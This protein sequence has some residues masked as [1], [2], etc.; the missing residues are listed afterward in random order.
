MANPKHIRNE[1]KEYLK[2]IS[3][4]D[5]PRIVFEEHKGIYKTAYILIKVGK[6]TNKTNKDD[7]E[8]QYSEGEY[9]VYVGIENFPNKAPVIKFLTPNGRYQKDSPICLNGITHYHDGGWNFSN[10][11]HSTLPQSL[12]GTMTDDSFGIRGI[13]YMYMKPEERLK[14][15]SSS[16]EFN[17]INYPRI[18][19]MFN[20]MEPEVLNAI[21]NNKKILMNLNEKTKEEEDDILGELGLDNFDENLKF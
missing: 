21:E 13:A 4:V 3:S 18:I 8:Y 20:E 2:N 15:A 6:K 14:L 19:N 16:K 12:L 9:I 11:L 1:I 5:Q 10:N 7:L 17:K